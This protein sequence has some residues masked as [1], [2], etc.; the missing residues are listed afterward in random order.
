MVAICKLSATT[1]FVEAF[2][3]GVEAVNPHLLPLFPI[4]WVLV[5]YFFNEYNR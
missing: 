1:H 4:L 3:L 2:I 5:E